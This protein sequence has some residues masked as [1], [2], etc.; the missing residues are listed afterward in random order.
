MSRP[1]AV[2]PACVIRWGRSLMRVHV[3]VAGLY[4]SDRVTGPADPL[5]P[6]KTYILSPTVAVSA[7]ARPMGLGARVDQL[8]LV[9]DPGTGPG[10]G[11]GGGGVVAG[12]TSIS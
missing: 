4:T 3:F 5:N 8:I 2:T 11:G 1:T 6:P 9:N 10:G 7:S 12:A